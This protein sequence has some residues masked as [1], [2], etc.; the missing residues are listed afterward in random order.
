MS[1][2]GPGPGLGPEL[3]TFGGVLAPHSVTNSVRTAA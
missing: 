1:G 2:P 3:V